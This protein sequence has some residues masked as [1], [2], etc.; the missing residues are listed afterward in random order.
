LDYRRIYNGYKNK[1]EGLVSLLISLLHAGHSNCTGCI[2]IKSGLALLLISLLHA[3][4]SDWNGC[5][6]IKKRT[7]IAANP[8][9]AYRVL[10]FAWLYKNKKADWFNCKSL[11]C[12]KGTQIVVVVQK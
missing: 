5:T 11:F 2:K 4:H 12:M 3:G 9:F 10:K 7:G 1:K 6:K 8:S